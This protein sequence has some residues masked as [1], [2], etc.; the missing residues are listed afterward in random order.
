MTQAPTR[1]VFPLPRGMVA[2]IQPDGS[3]IVLGTDGATVAEVSE[4]T[5]HGARTLYTNDGDGYMVYR[6]T[7]TTGTALS[8]CQYLAGLV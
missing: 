5:K 4:P 3:A 7:V 8:H 6:C 2:H 1:S